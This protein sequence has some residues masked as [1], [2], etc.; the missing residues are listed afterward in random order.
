[1]A[2][3]QKV[4]EKRP[5]SILPLEVFS[6]FFI[7]CIISLYSA[8]IRLVEEGERGGKEEDLSSTVY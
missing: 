3:N 7:P 5:K 1:M 6:V 8:N 4:E 2:S